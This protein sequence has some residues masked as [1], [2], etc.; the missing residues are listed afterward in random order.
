MLGGPEPSLQTFGTPQSLYSIGSILYDVTT[1]VMCCCRQRNR[2]HRLGVH[3]LP[4]L[5]SKRCSSICRALPV[6][7]T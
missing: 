6:P 5:R 3:L 7:L 1:H 4:Q 2:R